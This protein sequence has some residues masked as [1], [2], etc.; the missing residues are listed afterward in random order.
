MLDRE[1]SNFGA[2]VREIGY[3]LNVVDPVDERSDLSDG[4]VVIRIRP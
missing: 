1:A 4:E 2:N 3:S